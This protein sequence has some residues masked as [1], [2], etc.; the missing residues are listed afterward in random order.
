VHP[1]SLVFGCEKE[2]I[3]RLPEAERAVAHSRSGAILRPRRLMS[4]SSSRQLCALSRI[5]V[6]KPTSSFLP[7][8]VAPIRT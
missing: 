4:T 3:E 1:A 6:W 5:P 2:L 7:S 8:G